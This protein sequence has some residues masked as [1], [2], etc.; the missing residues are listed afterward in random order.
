MDFPD[1]HQMLEVSQ[2]ML[3]EQRTA[4]SGQSS[5]KNSLDKPLQWL[6][7]TFQRAEI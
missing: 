2:Y 3:G 7:Y 1:T 4:M 6:N 5:Q